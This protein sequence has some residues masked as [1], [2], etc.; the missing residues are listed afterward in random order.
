MWRPKL[1]EKWQKP[2]LPVFKAIRAS[3][4]P[5]LCGLTLICLSACQDNVLVQDNSLFSENVVRLGDTV[6]AEVDG[7]Q[8]YLSDVENAALT[9]SLIKTGAGLVPAD[10]IFQKILDELIDQ[11]LLALEALR[12]SLDQND[13]TR[14]R[15]AIS[16]E[17]ILSNVVIET[18]IS[19]NVTEDALQ[20]LYTEQT[21]KNSRG[22]QVRARKIVLSSE[23][24]AKAMMKL[25][26]KP[27]ADFAAIAKKKTIDLSTRD[28]GGDLGYFQKGAMTGSVENLAF[29]TAVG[30]IAGPIETDAGWVIIRV[31]NKRPIPVPKYDDIKDEIKNFMTFDTIDKLLKSLRSQS[32]IELRLGNVKTKPA[33]RQD[34]A[35]PASGQ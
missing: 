23:D 30:E 33:P 35:K 26:N 19:E 11:R 15:L 9:K 5:I 16:R 17:R 18:L 8:I 22:E 32:M 28:L 14:R 27:K 13:D 10:P 12:R 29:E 7:T 2:H 24:D 6:V 1:L 4:M 20:R 25:L 31:E 3:G 21:N 34:E